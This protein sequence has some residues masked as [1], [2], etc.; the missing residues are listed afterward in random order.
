MPRMRHDQPPTR[1]ALADPIRTGLVAHTY[2]RRVVI[3]EGL[4]RATDRDVRHRVA[5]VIERTAMVRVAEPIGVVLR[6]IARLD[7]ARRWCDGR[8][9]RAHAVPPALAVRGACRR[10]MREGH[11]AAS[12]VTSMSQARS[13]APT[14]GA[15]TMIP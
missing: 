13:H 12:T 15:L 8:R 1:P 2:Q 3:S 6:A 9:S 7:R 4:P 11:D 14:V 10:I 5:V